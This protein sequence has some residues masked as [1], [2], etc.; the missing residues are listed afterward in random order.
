MGLIGFASRERFRRTFCRITSLTRYP[1]PMFCWILSSH[2]GNSCQIAPVK[3]NTIEYRPSPLI[4]TTIVLQEQRTD[5]FICTMKFCQM[6]IRESPSYRLW[7]GTNSASFHS[8][9]TFHTRLLSPRKSG[10]K[11]DPPVSGI[12]RSFRTSILQCTEANESRASGWPLVQWRPTTAFCERRI[13]SSNRF[14]KVLMEITIPYPLRIRQ[15]RWEAV[16]C[17]LHQAKTTINQ[18]THGF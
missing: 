14:L 2:K 12:Q 3:G 1:T 5:W 13:A 16:G 4:R 8:L 18:S 6:T 10:Q 17:A 9:R 11:W 15:L 7:S